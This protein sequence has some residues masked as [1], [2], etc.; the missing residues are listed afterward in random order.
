MA[1]NLFKR[2]LDVELDKA[3]TD[4]N[5][6]LSTMEIINYVIKNPIYIFLGILILSLNPLKDFL[7]IG[8]EDGI[9]NFSSLIST[10]VSGVIAFAFYLFSKTTDSEFRGVV[11]ALRTNFEEKMKEIMDSCTKLLN[12]KDK[13]IFQLSESLGKEKDEHNADKINLEL[14]KKEKEII[15]EFQSSTNFKKIPMETL[16][17]G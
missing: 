4:N 2:K 12:E 5:G 1:W 10:L 17:Q 16:N 13:T 7:I 8:L 15:K 14:E 11:S 9:W 6:K 3:D